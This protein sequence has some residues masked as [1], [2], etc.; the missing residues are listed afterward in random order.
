MIYNETIK[1]LRRIFEDILNDLY[2]GK[3]D[4]KEYC[5]VNNHDFENLSE[6]EKIR[7]L[8]CYTG[9]RFYRNAR[10]DDKSIYK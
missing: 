4:F 10:K 1:P 9:Y 2:D 3:D 5:E 8:K 7:I 6:C